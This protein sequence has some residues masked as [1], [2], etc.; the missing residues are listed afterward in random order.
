MASLVTQERTWAQVPNVGATRKQQ[1]PY[2]YYL[3]LVEKQKLQEAPSL[4]V[5]NVRTDAQERHFAEGRE[6]PRLEQLGVA[7]EAQDA[8]EVAERA[9]VGRHLL[10]RHP[11][12]HAL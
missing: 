1:V 3:R 8:E 11:L 9:R 10:L 2:K 12:Q 5:M 6:Q 4:Q 7:H